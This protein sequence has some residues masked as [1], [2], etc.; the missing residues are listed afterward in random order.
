MAQQASGEQSSVIPI[1][2]LSGHGKQ[3]IV[4][5]LIKGGDS[6]RRTRS[7]AIGQ[8]PLASLSPAGQQQVQQILKELSLFRRLP[9][10]QFDVDRRTYEYF[11]EHPDVAV[12]IWR[13]LE[14]SSVQ[15]KEINSLQYQTDTR[16][17]TVGNVD[18]LLRSPG[19]YLVICQGQLQSP[20]MLRPIHAKAL[21]HVQPRFDNNG[22]VVHHLDMF[23]SF[24]SQT[25]ETIARLT[26]PVSFRIADRNF[27]E[28]SLFIAL[29]SNAM[30]QQP[31]W[32]EQTARQLEGV[33]PQRPQELLSVTASV[34]VDAER[35][36]LTA[37]G[38]PINIE[39]I[40]P[41]VATQTASEAEAGIV[42]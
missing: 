6:S 29:M 21:M 13:A 27:E 20:G 31:G 9:T 23:V 1:N 4:A 38:Q 22:K 11:T 28:V 37:S 39:S 10:L 14:I 40:R 18:V 24:P 36:R 42:R 32:V 16:D 2:Q 7:E 19:S 12:S 26:S 34:Y 33:A 35:R 8:L 17:G 3:P 25:I 5:N 15:M 41:P 30:S